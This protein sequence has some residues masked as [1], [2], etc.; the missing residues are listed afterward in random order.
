MISIIIP[1]YNNLK[2]L[3]LCIESIKKNS[4]YNNEILVH[5]NEGKDGS[6]DYLKLDNKYLVVSKGKKI[7]KIDLFDHLKACCDH[8]CGEILLNSV[9]RDGKKKGYDLEI[10]DKVINK[11][12][13]PLI[14]L[15]GAGNSDHFVEAFSKTKISSLISF[16]NLINTT[17]HLVTDLYRLP[18]CFE[19][20]LPS[21][22]N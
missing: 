4:K 6:I 12:N 7:T 13:I 2:Y 16:L 21:I 19:I 1:S 15:G 18:I 17:H 22:P 20:K 5:V 14:I 3:K 11:I 10:I 8:G 9:E